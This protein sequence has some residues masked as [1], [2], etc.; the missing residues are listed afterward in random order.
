[1]KVDLR[2]YSETVW[3][4]IKLL[5][6]D[7]FFGSH[8]FA[9]L[10]R[11]LRGNPVCWTVE[12]RGEV[13][14]AL[15]GVE[16]GSRWWRR[17]YA[18]PDG[19]YG[20]LFRSPEE[21]IDSGILARSV[22]DALVA[23]GYVKLYVFDFYESLPPDGRFDLQS[24]ETT[25]VDISGPDWKPQHKKLQYEIRRAEREGTEFCV[26]D[27]DR[28][29]GAFLNLMRQTEQRHQQ[30]PRYPPE[31]F[32]AL[33]ELSQRDRRIRW[34]WCEYQGQPVCCHICFI[35]NDTLQGWQ[36]YLD[37]RFSFLKANQFMRYQ[38]CREVAREGVRTLNL[39]LTPRD[40]SGLLFYKK[41][42]GGRPKRYHC[43]VLRRGLGRFL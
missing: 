22:Q 19:C 12:H 37:K 35:E 24:R 1:M 28:H 11:R 30:T 41:R 2:P 40:A 16:F 34:V 27:W 36:V 20:R 39:G 13:I 3:D 33:A 43:H 42:W 10:W 7:S 25:L 6:G 32:E 9:D 31:F 21:E 14:G 29:H 17:F 18:M 26:F 5:I 38:M 8:G 15:P 4:R 23:R